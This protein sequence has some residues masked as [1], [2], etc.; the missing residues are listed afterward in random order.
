MKFEERLAIVA[1]ALL[2][3]PSPQVV[4]GLR[5]GTL[6]ERALE[7]LSLLPDGARAQTALY[8]TGSWPRSVAKVVVALLVLIVA[9]GLAAVVSSSE[10]VSVPAVL[11]GTLGLQSILLVLWIVALLPGAGPLL[12]RACAALIAGPI[13][14]LGS[15]RD[16]AVSSAGEAPAPRAVAEWTQRRVR[17]L[18][19][20][21]AASLA[22]AGALSIA[23]APRRSNLAALVYGV[24]S[25]GAWIAANILVLALLSLRLL[26]SRTYTLHSGLLSP[27]ATRTWVGSILEILAWM[28][29]GDWLPSA[30]A[31][32][33]AS[34]EP[35]GVAQDSWHWGAMLVLSVAVFGLLPRVAA[36]V[37]AA[38]WLPA[39]RRSWRIP[40]DER[41]LAPTR[42]VIE[43]A[44]PPTTVLAT[45]RPA[46]GASAASRRDAAKRGE[47]PAI[48]G[49][50]RVTAWTPTRPATML[51]SLEQGGLA[52]AEALAKRVMNDRLAPIVVL[53]DLVAAPRRGVIDYLAPIVAS[54]ACIAV[55]SEGSRLR[56]GATDAD[57]ATVVQSWRSLLEEVGIAEVHELDLA[58]RTSASGAMLP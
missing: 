36:L 7:R 44:R 29:P 52:G 9:T 2:E 37:I 35:A 56:R 20:D 25:N 32:A 34:V 27:E 39:A 1:L 4:D 11:V 10:T 24:W 54:G 42:V 31:L 14:T 41:T 46:S 43:S 28:V 21:H 5:A 48:V 38:L 13:R 55:L 26:G 33:R 15:L 8:A 19:T 45:E 18:Q 3:G 40:W 58:M 17:G 53:V 6:D 16:L 23:Y 50:G 49:I 12:R 57:F 47:A 30:E 22:A 51:G